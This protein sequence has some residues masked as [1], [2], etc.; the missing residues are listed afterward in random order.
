MMNTCLIISL[1]DPHFE[2]YQQNYNR[3]SYEPIEL[4]GILE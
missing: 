2:G 4:V 1:K 3:W